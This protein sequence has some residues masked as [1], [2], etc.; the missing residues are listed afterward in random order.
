MSHAKLL[1]YYARLSSAVIIKIL[2]ATLGFWSG[3]KLDAILGTEP[4]L[5]FLGFVAGVSLGLWWVI[6][7]ANRTEL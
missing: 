5:M 2:L 3:R 1:R 7:T 6:R 4:F